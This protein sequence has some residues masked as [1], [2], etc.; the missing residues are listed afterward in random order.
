[1][2]NPNHHIGIA[3]NPAVPPRKTAPRVA[4]RP[5]PAPF[6]QQAV[7]AALAAFAFAAIGAALLRAL[8]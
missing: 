4:V 7:E 8:F 5:A 1:M 6:A 3:T 2:R